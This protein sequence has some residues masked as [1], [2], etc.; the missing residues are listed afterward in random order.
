[1]L[2][3]FVSSR[4]FSLLHLIQ[5]NDRADRARSVVGLKHTTVTCGQ[6]RVL[7]CAP[8][9][10]SEPSC[11]NPETPMIFFSISKHGFSIRQSSH[12]FHSVP[13]SPQARKLFLHPPSWLLRA[14]AA[15][16][17]LWCYAIVS[18]SHNAADAYSNINGIFFMLP[19]NVKPLSRY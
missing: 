10:G 4:G 5:N 1:M 16:L 19:N 15:L 14:Q 17:N 8:A 7:T 9:S 2:R 12:P 18:I 6:L 11:R 13:F 3:L